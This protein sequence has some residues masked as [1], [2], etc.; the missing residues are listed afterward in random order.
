LGQYFKGLSP[1]ITLDENGNP[2]FSLEKSPMIKKA[3]IG[4]IFSIPEEIGKRNN[5]Y[6]CIAFDEF[7]EYKRIDPFLVNQMRSIFQ[8]QKN[9]SYIF[10]GSKQSLM[11]SIFS[12][13]KSPFYEFGEKMNIDPIKKKD[14]H[15]FI[16]KKFKQTGLE[17][18][19]KTI[20]NILDVSHG[21]PHYT[22]Y[23]SAVVWNL[24]SEGE[25]QNTQQFSQQ[26]LDLVINSQSDIFQNILDQLTTNQRKV[27]K[28]LS[29]SDTLQLYGKATADA[30]NFP[31][32]STLNESIK[33]L[34]NKD[35]ITKKNGFYQI[36]NPIMKEWLKNL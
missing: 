21:H 26:W 6:I 1:S 15:Q 31:S 13:A 11:Q 20:D 33:G 34:M 18:G 28:A 19:K 10:M 4:K 23:F 35:I 16:Y 2:A 9:V 8:T 5:I 36:A 25:D 32:D 17:I 14:W 24:I 29:T 12:D 7:Q 22:Q 27:L 3:D 30:F